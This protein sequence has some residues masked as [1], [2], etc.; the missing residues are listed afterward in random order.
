MKKVIEQ[1]I[2]FTNCFDYWCTR[3]WFLSDASSSSELT[4][5]RVLGAQESA[6]LFISQTEATN[7]DP[8]AGLHKLFSFSVRGLLSL[9]P[10]PNRTAGGVTSNYSIQITISEIWRSLCKYSALESIILSWL[11]SWWIMKIIAWLVPGQPTGCIRGAVIIITLYLSA[12][13]SL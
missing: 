12:P 6:L 5:R 10:F 8:I 2:S 4:L 7:N 13:V 3:P 11:E 9:N 1:L